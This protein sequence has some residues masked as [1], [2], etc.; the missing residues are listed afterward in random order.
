MRRLRFGIEES[1]QC[2]C[3]DVEQ[4]AGLRF[5][6]IITDDDGL[7]IGQQFTFDAAMG[8]VLRNEPRRLWMIRQD[9]RKFMADVQDLPLYAKRVINRFNR[10]RYPS[11]GDIGLAEEVFAGSWHDEMTGKT[12]DCLGRRS[13]IA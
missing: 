3:D 5:C 2:I 6:V 12:K 4:R 13:Y 11:G 9:L 7:D 1:W 10:E 8:E